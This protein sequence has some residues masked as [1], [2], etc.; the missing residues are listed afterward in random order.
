[1]AKTTPASYT[2]PVFLDVSPSG[3]VRD[4]TWSDQSQRLHHLYARSGERIPLFDGDEISTTSLSYIRSDELDG[5][6]GVWR[7]RRVSDGDVYLLGLTAYGEDID[8]RVTVFDV[9]AD[10]SIDT[11]D[12]TISPGPAWGTTTYSGAAADVLT[13]GVPKLLGL[14]VQI[15]AN[16]TEATLYQLFAH[17]AVLTSAQIP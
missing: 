9:V 2:T 3:I 4:D 14:D 15:R 17:A 12:L 11:F 16:T 1:M 5:I 10:A 6:V 8:I 13:S 7:P